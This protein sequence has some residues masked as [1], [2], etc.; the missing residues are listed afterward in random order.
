MKLTHL[1]KKGE[2][3][4]VPV[5]AKPIVERYA[6]ARG[7]IKMSPS[8]LEKIRNEKIPKGSV[9]ACARIAGIQAA[10]KT[11]DLIPLCH[12][13]NLDHVSIDFEFQEGGIEVQAQVITSAKTGVEM[14]ALTAVN[15]ALLT[16]YDMCKAVDKN[17]FFEN[18]RLLEK[19]KSNKIPVSAGMTRSVI[20]AKAGIQ[21]IL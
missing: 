13:L 15:V 5:Q 6:R 4:Q 18:I 1:D 8:V 12:S 17:M 2:I 21:D 11:A 14:E 16:I 10:K 3:R 20:P 7:F 19:T 9:F